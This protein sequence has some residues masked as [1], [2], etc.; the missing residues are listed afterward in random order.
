LSIAY[1]EVGKIHN[2]YGAKTPNEESIL[3]AMAQIGEVDYG[4][5]YFIIE[6]KNISPK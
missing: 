3:G 5:K 6:G 2:F 4:I 1:L